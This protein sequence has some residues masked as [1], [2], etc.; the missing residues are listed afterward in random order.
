M[1]LGSSSYLTD[2]FGRPTHYYDQLPFGESMVEH[3][4][5]QYYGNQYKFNGKELDAATGMYY[6][7]ARYYDPRISIFVSVDPLAER[8]MTPYQYVNNDPINFIDPTGMEGES[9]IIRGANEEYT[10]N[11]EDKYTGNDKFIKSTLSAIEE[12]KQSQTGYHMVQELDHSDHDF[13]IQSGTEDNFDPKNRMMADASVSNRL[14]D[15]LIAKNGVGSG[16]TINW[17]QQDLRLPTTTTD[18]TSK[19]LI[20]GHEMG[21]AL[22][23]NRGKLDSRINETSK[24]AGENFKRSEW[25]AVY[26]E[27]LMRSELGLPLR[28]HYGRDIETGTGRYL[29]PSGTRML[30][31]NNE[32]IKPSWYE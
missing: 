9:I 10:Y 16:G 26:R 6:Y 18:L 25:Q 15:N 30:G 23:S 11:E 28:T 13:F 8:T 7:G 20:L 3:N 24:K 19:V 17:S 5:S 2:N 14:K 32:I 4:Q 22:D 29:G 1:H 31:P 27:N 12:I 21:H